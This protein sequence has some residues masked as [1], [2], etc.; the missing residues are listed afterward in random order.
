[1]VD[2]TGS[3][4]EQSWVQR[5]EEKALLGL[6]LHFFIAIIMAAVFVFAASRIA[7]LTRFAWVTGPLFGLVL[8]AAMQ[9]VVL[10]LSAA[11]GGSHPEGQFFWGALAA[12]TLLVGL[13]I[14]LVAR[15]V[16]PQ[17]A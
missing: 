17:S 4:I 13:P 5:P 1:M 7:F 16:A 11:G 15:R 10:P 2:C 6:A 8:Y 14:A 3:T 12:H 9:Y